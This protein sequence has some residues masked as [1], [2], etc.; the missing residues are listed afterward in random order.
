MCRC[1]RGCSQ[2]LARL[3]TDL[4]DGT[5]DRHHGHLRSQPSLDVGLRLITAEIDGT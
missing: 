4:A 2:V 3:Q 1:D 5:S